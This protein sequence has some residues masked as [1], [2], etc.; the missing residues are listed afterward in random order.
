MSSV[1]LF[2]PGPTP[3]PSKV[4]EAG[5]LPMIHHRSE[6]FREILQ[7]VRSRLDWLCDTNGTTVPFAS[8][9]SGAMEAAVSS[10][11]KKGDEVV[12]VAAGKFGHR[13]EQLA[14]HF[15]LQVK[16]IK[17]EWGKAVD[18]GDVLSAVSKQTKGVLIQACESSAGIYHPVSE[19]GAALKANDNLIYAVDAITGIGVHDLSM[20]R[21]R[22]DALVGGSQ[23]ALMCPPGLS[24]VSLSQRALTRVQEAT[25]AGFYFSLKRN[26]KAL[27][28]GD[29]VF[30]PA[31]SL[32]RSLDMALKAIEAEGKESLFARQRLMQKMSRAAFRENGFKLL[33]EDK[34][35]T[36]GITAVCALE[37]MDVKA[38]LKKL[39]ADEGLWLAG[40]QDELAGKIFRI[41]HM[42]DCQPKDLLGALETIEESL[43][44]EF[45]VMSEK[46]GSKVARKMMEQ[47]T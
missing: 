42:G 17:V 10:L 6:E 34:D 45:P 43:Q 32:M 29:T 33:N 47:S 13:W 7:S 39:K 12:V 25:D 1:R 40:G 24:F 28:K 21:D 35:A 11:F 15:G 14:V 16:L 20:K 18:T 37:G 26:L 22:I 36:W 31:V 30:T 2:T 4:R 44:E 5:A 3:V 19:I 38:W 27:E 46:R 23:K 9:G 41:S 8:S